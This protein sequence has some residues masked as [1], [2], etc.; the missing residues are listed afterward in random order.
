M[1]PISQHEDSFEHKYGHSLSGQN[2][3]SQ[4][5]KPNLICFHLLFLS[6][7]NLSKYC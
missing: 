4:R 3:H 2:G 5:L 7:V 6:L 1:H